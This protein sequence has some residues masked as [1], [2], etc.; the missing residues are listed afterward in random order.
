MLAVMKAAGFASA[1]V[2]GHAIGGIT[3]LN[4]ARQAPDRVRSLVLVNAWGR[5]DAH[6]RR[7]FSV[8]KEILRASGPPAYVQAQPLFLYPPQWNADHDHELREEAEF[9]V[10]QFPSP[11]LLA[12]RIEAFTG[13]DAVGTLGVLATP[14]LVVASGDDS[15]VPVGLSRELAA[16]IPGARLVEFEYGAHACTVVAP[17][18]FNPVLTGFLEEIDQRA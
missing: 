14:T 18:R 10:S 11:Q 6:L 9:Q 3:G 8:R 5:A 4:L 2:V 16:A 1:H 12:D 13:F 15:L 17:E 7:C